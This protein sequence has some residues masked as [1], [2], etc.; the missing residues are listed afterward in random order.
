MKR[1]FY[2]TYET[3]LYSIDILA[4]SKII[5][6][7]LHIRFII[8]ISCFLAFIY[9]S[10]SDDLAPANLKEIAKEEEE[11]EEEEEVVVVVNDLENPAFVIETEL[12]ISEFFDEAKVE[13][14]YVLVNDA[15]SNSAFLMDKRSEKLFDFE[16]NGKRIGND[17]QLLPDGRL[18]AMLEVDDPTIK[19]GGFGGLIQLLGNDG[20]VHWS[21]E[22]SSVDYIAHHD[23]ELLPNGNIIFQIWER[24]TAEESL[25][26]GYTL[27]VDVFPDGIIEVNP[28]NN[29]I[30]WEWRAWNHLIQEHDETKSNFGVIADNPQLI[31]V[32]YITDEKGDIMHANGIS[33]DGNNDVIYLSANFFSEVW[34]ID[35]STTTAEAASNTGGN[36]GKGG[37]LLYR[38]GNP[39]AYDNQTGTVRFDHNHYPNL[40]TGE[41]EGKMLI[42]SNGFSSGRSTVYELRLPGIFDL[43]PNADNEPEVLW[44]FTNDSLFSGKVSGAVKLPN[45]NRLITEGDRGYWEVTEEGAVVWRFKGNGFFWRGY[46]FD[47]NAPEL[48]DLGL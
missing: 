18:L 10:C 15:S 33:Y 35:H 22:Y 45:G 47:K 12:G 7:R 32:N 6:M 17:V 43:Q 24:K 25:D 46:H 2:T 11:E 31:N 26:A 44:S 27:E 30:V 37:N 42:F 3:L 21:Y 29:E 36:Y 14:S 38:F 4:H 16:L 20:S 9:T 48:I 40:L 34:V 23:A 8:I 19:I 39:K 1:L 41:D 13:D 5:L 28:D